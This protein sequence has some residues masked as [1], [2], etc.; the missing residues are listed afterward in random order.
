MP[1]RENERKSKSAKL[2]TSA[3]LAKKEK[4]DSSSAAVVS[5]TY[6]DIIDTLSVSPSASNPS[7]VSW[8]DQ[9]NDYIILFLKY[10]FLV[11]L[12]T[13]NFLGLSVSLNCNADQELASRVMSA[14]FAFFFGF[15]YLLVNYYTYKVMTQGKMC[16]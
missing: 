6:E 14:I 5:S 4:F 9:L 8:Q 12:L 10:A 3:K 11:V 13:L 15:V 7:S 16:K 2:A 1:K